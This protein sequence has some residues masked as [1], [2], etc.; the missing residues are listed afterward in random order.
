MLNL[1]Y[2]GTRDEQIYAALSARMA[3]VYDIFGSLPD[4]IED[5]WID[6]ITSLNERLASYTTRRNEAA[7]AFDIRYPGASTA[8]GNAWEKCERVLGRRDIVQLMSKG[9]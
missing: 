9:W 6:D 7:N 3:D 1:V 8:K 2:Q 5:E 4:T